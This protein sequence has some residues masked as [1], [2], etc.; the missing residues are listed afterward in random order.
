MLIDVPRLSVSW[1]SSELAEVSSASRQVW[2]Q[3]SIVQ[4]VLQPSRRLHVYFASTLYIYS[5]AWCVDDLRC[6][7]ASLH[8]K[9]ERVHSSDISSLNRRLLRDVSFNKTAARYHTSYS[10][11]H[12]LGYLFNSFGF[13][14]RH[15]HEVWGASTLWHISNI[16][17]ALNRLHHQYQL[18]SLLQ[19]KP[20]LVSEGD[21]AI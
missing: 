4:V 19:S 12:Y 7:V 10:Y 14:M 21:T 15:L 20:P 11:H 5:W 1:I 18:K 6:K 13:I 16:I 8:P 9:W 3:V 2:Y 17:C